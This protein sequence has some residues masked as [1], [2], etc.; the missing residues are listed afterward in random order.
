MNQN[1][2]KDELNPTATKITTN[3]LDKVIENEATTCNW[4]GETLNVGD[5]RC[6]DG[7]QYVCRPNGEVGRTG[8]NC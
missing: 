5:T 4:Q 1:E 7:I 2:K 8:R 6:K 3:D